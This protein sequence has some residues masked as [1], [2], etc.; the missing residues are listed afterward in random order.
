MVSSKFS[1]INFLTFFIASSF[2]FS[3]SPITYECKLSVL[4]SNFVSFSCILSI[5]SLVVSTFDK[6]SF[7]IFKN[8]FAFSD[9]VDELEGS[10]SSSITGGGSLISPLL[11][12]S[13]TAI[14]STNDCAILL[15]ASMK[16]PFFLLPSP[17]P[18]VSSLIFFILSSAFFFAASK[19]VLISFKLE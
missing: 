19:S 13:I 11:T 12:I 2:N 5:L 15:R 1:S 17:F 4:S 7:T 14:T 6:Y 9:K 3:K 10:A 16:A 8:F 18:P